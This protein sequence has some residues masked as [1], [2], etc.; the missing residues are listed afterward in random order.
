MKVA[1][2][3]IC[4]SADH[5]GGMGR[6]AHELAAATARLHQVLLI[7]PGDKLKVETV[8]KRLTVVR[9]PSRGRGQLLW[10]DLRDPTRRRVHSLVSRFS[11]QVV[12]AHDVGPLSLWLQD[13]ASHVGCPFALTFHAL[14]SRAREF[15]NAEEYR[16]LRFLFK[17]RVP[18]AFVRLVLS[19]C[20][21]VVALNQAVEDD[22]RRFGY[23]GLV[24]RI[25]NGRYPSPL[26]RLDLADITEPCKQLLF[27]GSICQSKNQR[28]L[29]EAISH[30]DMPARLVL[31][32]EI[33]EEGYSRELRRY[34]LAQGIDNVDFVGPVPY[35]TIPQFLRRA[36]LF[37]SAST[38]ELQSLAVLEALASGT[39]VVALEN[40][41]V[42]ELV[43]DAVGRKLPSNAPPAE[44]AQAVAEICRMNPTQYSAL[45]RAARDRV[46][47]LDWSAVV[48]KHTAA[49]ERLWG[50]FQVRRRRPF[51][52]PWLVA[53]SVARYWFQG[54]GT[55]RKG[56]KSGSWSAQ[57]V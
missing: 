5:S 35:E 50:G 53:G 25:P 43:D 36:H 46:R 39:P 30:L 11:P 1:F 27:V 54:T 22:V 38:L 8:G 13:W 17:M 26:L 14:P 32:G 56:R 48:E 23:R 19:R 12:H 31:V 28:Y 49:Y 33:L 44:F 21:G 47:D 51:W 24:F 55:R 29:V 41:T 40:A 57:G 18:Q 9:V 2:V 15:T 34:A 3:T 6:V 20:D 42:T 4:P 37:L 16:H 52:T 10:P 7:C 45:A